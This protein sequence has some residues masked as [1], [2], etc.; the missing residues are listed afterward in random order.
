M[1]NDEMMKRL[2]K[3][4]ITKRREKAMYNCWWNRLIM[5]EIDSKK[6]S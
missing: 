6:L 3:R 2:H 5:A 1:R 4:R